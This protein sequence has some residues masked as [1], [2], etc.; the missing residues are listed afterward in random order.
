MEALVPTELC[1]LVSGGLYRRFTVRRERWR[2][3]GTAAPGQRRD[4]ATRRQ[5]AAHAEDDPGDAEQVGEPACQQ[6]W[7]GDGRIDHREHG[8]ED[9][10]TQLRLR[11]LLQ[12][13][14]SRDEQRAEL[15]AADEAKDHG[16]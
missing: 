1:A 11:L 14:E 2:Y 12:D 3:K 6:Y 5:Q 10:A 15:E 8:A 7:G 9:A 16:E 13:R 4:H